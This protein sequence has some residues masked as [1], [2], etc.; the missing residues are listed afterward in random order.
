MVPSW[1]R[2][3]RRAGLLPKGA[4]AIPDSPARH[5]QAASIVRGSIKFPETC[6]VRSDPHAGQW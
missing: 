2:A 3:K 4:V 1:G 6:K 5:T